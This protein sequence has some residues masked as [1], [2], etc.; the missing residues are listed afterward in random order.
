MFHLLGDETNFIEWFSWILN[1]FQKSLKNDYFL[2]DET[3]FIDRFS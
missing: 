3:N 1:S 2:R